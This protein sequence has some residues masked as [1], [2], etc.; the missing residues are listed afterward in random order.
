ML[1][2]PAY[3]TRLA[4]SLAAIIVM[5][6]APAPSIAN[7]TDEESA[8]VV[9]RRA[10]EIA[11]QRGLDWLAGMQQESGAWSN[12]NFPALTAMPLWAMVRSGREDFRPN[13]QRATESILSCVRTSGP[14]KGAIYQP[15][16]GRRG[17]GLSNY[18]TALS[19]V[20]LHAVQT[21]PL[22]TNTNTAHTLPDLAPAILN[23]RAFLA[24]SQ[25]LGESLHHGGMG[26]DPPTERSYADL[27]NAYLGYEAMRITQ[28]IEEFRPGNARVDLD[29]TAAITFIQRIQNL[30]GINDQPWA[31]DHPAEIGG[32]TYRPDTYREDFGAF[33]DDLG[34]LRYRSARTM[35]FAG[36]LSYLYAGIDRDDPRI[37]AAVD[38]IRNHWNPYIPN[39]NPELAGTDEEMGGYYYYLTVMT[40]ALDVYGQETLAGS[41][42]NEIQWRNEVISAIVAQQQDD[43]FWINCYGRYWEAD[44]VLASAYALLA[45]QNALG[46]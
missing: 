37:A 12:T 27:S 22:R 28:A 39:R 8:S 30:P 11:M 5:L 44:P 14:D 25:Y 35:S 6:V 26:Y 41:D 7:D 10:A 34:I 42:G 24:S 19:V 2:N 15:V 18:N 40:R 17:G 21:S 23:A 4:L 45:L 43:G 9:Q 16:P 20:A 29:W 33:T 3:H 1:S 38:W 31:T 32:F 13:I 46:L 36:L